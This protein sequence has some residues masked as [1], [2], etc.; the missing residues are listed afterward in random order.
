MFSGKGKNSKWP[1]FI[2]KIKIK[3]LNS[4][5]SALIW[6]VLVSTYIH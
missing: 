2:T 6:T 1:K 3:G 4:M 5:M